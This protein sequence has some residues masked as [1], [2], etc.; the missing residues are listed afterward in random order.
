V[1]TTPTKALL[2]TQI[3][4]VGV[5][6]GVGLLSRVWQPD[7]DS[8][9]YAACLLL[10]LN[11]GWVLLSWYLARRTLFEP[12]PLFMVAAGLFHGGQAF[13]HVFGKDPDGL[14]Y[15]RVAP[16]VLVP[17]LYLVTLSLACVHGGAL[18]AA[19]RKLRVQTKGDAEVRNR[20][21]ATRLAGW[22]LLA[23]GFVPVLVMLQ[24]SVS[25]VMDYGYIGLYRRQASH[26]I[27]QAIS[28]FFVPGAIFLLSGARKIRGI[29]VFCLVL[30]GMYAAAYL[31]LGARG[32]AVM[33]LV[34]TVWTYHR[35]VRRIP[36][37]LI[38][39]LGL[40][41]LLLFPLVKETRD[42]GGR[43]R[44]SLKEQYETLTSI[45]NPIAQ[46]FSEMGNSLVTVTHTL[47]LVPA[48]RDFDGGTSYLYSLVAMVPNLGWE[49]HPS[50]AHGLLSD[51]LVRTVEPMVA[52]AGG[53][54][55]YSFIAEA[56][57]NFGWFGAPI[58]L[59][60]IGYLLMRL[61][62]QS[63]TSDPARHA[64]VASFLSFFFVF[65]R[66]ESAIVVRGLVWYA[67]LPYLLAAILTIRGRR[68]EDRTTLSAQQSIAPPPAR[69]WKEDARG[70]DCDA[71]APVSA[72]P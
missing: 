9:V 63:D 17:A 27:A 5:L 6:A 38:L 32:A 49:V 42:T 19:G 51:W 28:A 3:L 59:A 52:A 64:M 7:F 14:L 62:M 44:L 24:D 40:A 66:G 34:P 50:V 54:L 65:T 8:L 12:Y 60:F 39:V 2:S 70:R 58:W 21:R 15:G 37:T 23:V 67:C 57:L 25:V 45:E 61:F 47:S 36:R 72:H 71:G 46:S 69:V 11:V 1:R 31:F 13:L 29:Q 53:G 16:E 22:I 10:T 30:V 43:W 20:E 68:R 35:T 41:A 48:V 56:Y 33:S 4:V 18:F 26:S 55:G